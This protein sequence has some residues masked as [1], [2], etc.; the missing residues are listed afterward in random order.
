[1]PWTRPRGEIAALE[2][3]RHRGGEFGPEGVAAFFVDR[4]VADDGEGARAG[5]EENQD[6]VALRGGGHAEAFELF[7]RLG[8]GLGDFAA[9]D[10]DADFAGGLL[11]RVA[12]GGDDARVIDGREGKEKAHGLTSSLPRRRR[13][14]C[15]HRRKNCRRRRSIRPRGPNRRRSRHPR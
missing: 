15:R 8:D 14:S 4:R 1:M 3:L 2:V 11:L 5:G 10:D 7:L 12:N 6:T 9:R 13:Q